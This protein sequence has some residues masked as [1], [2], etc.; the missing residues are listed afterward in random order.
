MATVTVQS[1]PV[2]EIIELQGELLQAR[3]YCFDEWTLRSFAILHVYPDGG[4]YVIDARRPVR[5]V[6]KR[7]ELWMSC[8]LLEIGGTPRLNTRSVG[9]INMLGGVPPDSFKRQLLKGVA[10]IGFQV[11]G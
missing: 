3:L 2:Q 9:L 6:S 5:V 1:L 10:L 4:V 8:S 7:R 11:G